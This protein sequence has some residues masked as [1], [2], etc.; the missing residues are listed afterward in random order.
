M[1]I[2]TVAAPQGRLKIMNVDLLP[3]ALSHYRHVKAFGLDEE[4]F[5]E[6]HRKKN[7][8]CVH[9]HH[10]S[11]HDERGGSVVRGGGGMISMIASSNF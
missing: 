7:L 9:R 3:L 5:K 8:P 6:A 10:H 1:F 11:H 2:N 4:Q